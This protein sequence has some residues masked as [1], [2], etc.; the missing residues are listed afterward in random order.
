[1]HAVNEG[2]KLFCFKLMDH[3]KWSPV[4]CGI[5]RFTDCEHCLSLGGY[6]ISFDL[7][8]CRKFSSDVVSIKALVSTE[9]IAQ[10]I[11]L[12]KY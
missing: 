10:L 1:M 9:T 7:E 2:P 11:L 3:I 12:I 6:Y 5:S 4:V 8:L